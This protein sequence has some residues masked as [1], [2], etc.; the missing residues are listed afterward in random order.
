[1]SPKDIALPN[2]KIDKFRDL[3]EGDRNLLVP[4][5]DL[6]A[7]VPEMGDTFEYITDRPRLSFRV[8]HSSQNMGENI[9]DAKTAL[10]SLSPVMPKRT[11]DYTWIK[12][13][14]PLDTPKDHLLTYGPP[15]TELEVHEYAGERYWSGKF[16]HEPSKVW[17]DVMKTYSSAMSPTCWVYPVLGRLSDV[18]SMHLMLLYQMSIL[19]RYRPAIWRE[20]IEGDHNAFRPLILGYSKVFARV[21]PEMALRRIAT[22]HV[23][24]TT[25]GSLF[26]PI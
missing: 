26:A 12:L 7:R 16:A 15:L 23:S 17:H 25:P 19:A 8:F 22:E 5:I 14:V 20:I 2:T 10:G 13:V 1:M 21:I 24:V 4:M 6:M 11:R 18:F 9:D 3:S